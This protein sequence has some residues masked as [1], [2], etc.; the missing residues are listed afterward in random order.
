MKNSI[1]TFLLINL[2]LSVALITALAIVGNLVLAH[3]DIQAE[4]DT[5]LIKLNAITFYEY[6]KPSIATSSSPLKTPPTPSIMQKFFNYS[7]VTSP[8]RLTT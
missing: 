2:L 7:T 3:Q 8:L 5:Q 4:L 1:R 6:R